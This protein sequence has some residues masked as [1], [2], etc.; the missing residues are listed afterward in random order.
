[1]N[2]GLVVGVLL[3]LLL[4]LLLNVAVMLWAVVDD[5]RVLVM[6]GDVGVD[7]THGKRSSKTCSGIKRAQ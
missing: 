1:M 5:S 6:I 3:L 2:K 7:A 4:L